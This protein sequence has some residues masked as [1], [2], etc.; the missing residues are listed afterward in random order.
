MAPTTSNARTAREPD[1]VA[2]FSLTFPHVKMST[3]AVLRVFGWELYENA[4]ARR[5]TLGA[6]AASGETAPV[7]RG[8]LRWAMVVTLKEWAWESMVTAEQRAGRAYIA[9]RLGSGGATAIELMT[10]AVLAD[11]MPRWCAAKAREAFDVFRRAA[12]VSPGEDEGV[13]LLA[14]EPTTAPD[15][16]SVVRSWCARHAQTAE[17]VPDTAIHDWLAVDGPVDVDELYRL[18]SLARDDMYV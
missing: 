10:F 17:V 18:A 4:R 14:G 13:C 9:R 12:R 3:V 8:A 16:A 11:A 7:S 15:E 5:A 2:G 6:L 1:P